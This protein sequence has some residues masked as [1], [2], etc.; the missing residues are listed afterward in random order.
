[1]KFQ[2][3]ISNPE[4]WYCE[5]AALNMPA[6]LE[7]SAVATGLEKVSFHS[8]H[9]ERQ[10]QRMLKLPHNRTHLTHYKSNAQNP[11]SQ[12][13]TVHEPWTSRC[14]SW[15][16]KRQRNQRSNCQHLLDHQKS[17]RV[18]EKHLFLL[19]WLWQS[20]SLCGPQQTMGNSLSDGNIRT[21]WAAS[22]EICMQLKM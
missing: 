14:S 20:L 10:C 9:K 4:R 16:Y 21:T 15:I 13:S 3:A 8:N 7:N 6:N 2:L 11:P 17:K 12:A 19:Y 18:P 22:W 1:M 5:G